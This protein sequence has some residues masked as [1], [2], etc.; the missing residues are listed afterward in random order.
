MTSMEA[1]ITRRG[2]PERIVKIPCGGRP[3]A[4][5]SHRDLNGLFRQ[6]AD[7]VNPFA[8]KTETV[9]EGT[10]FII[11]AAAGTVTVGPFRIDPAA[12]QKALREPTAT[13]AIWHRDRMQGIGAHGI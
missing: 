9:A 7:L 3:P 1:R 4:Q 10:I 8:V 5:W 12:L 13:D 6:L 11:E 2:E